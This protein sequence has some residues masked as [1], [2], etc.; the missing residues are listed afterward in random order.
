ME[1][2]ISQL[3][4]QAL[5]NE[6]GIGENALSTGLSANAQQAQEA[7]TKQQ[8]EQNSILGGLLSGGIGALAGSAAS[9]LPFGG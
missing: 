7:E 1:K 9:F 2:L 3:T 8:E 6:T 4:G 5:T